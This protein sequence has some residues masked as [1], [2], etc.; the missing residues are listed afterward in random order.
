MVSLNSKSFSFLNDKELYG[1]ITT[2]VNL[3]L[4]NKPSSKS[5]SQDLFCFAKSCLCNLFASLVTRSLK[6]KSCWSRFFL[7]FEIS[8][9]FSNFSALAISSK[10]LV[11]ILYSFSS[12]II[13]NFCDIFFEELSTFSSTSNCSSILNSDTSLSNSILLEFCSSDVSL[14]LFSFLS[15]FIELSCCL[16]LSSSLFW[17]VSSSISSKFNS[18]NNS[19]N[20]ELKISWLFIFLIKYF[21]CFF[22]VLLNFA[23]K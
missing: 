15:S 17:L 20:F 22:I 1:S 4:S 13:F 19:K 18:L 16:S 5:N 11:Y 7:N 9:L 8:S 10:L 3:E 12:L 6:L 23:S 2:L 21:L 14:L